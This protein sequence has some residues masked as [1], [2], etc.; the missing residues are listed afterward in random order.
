MG[1]YYKPINVDKKQ[2]V[3]SPAYG[4]GLKLM[5]HSW[6]G[7]GFVGVVEDLVAEGGAWHGDRIVWAGDYADDEK[8]R[9][10]NLWSLIGDKDKNEIQ[11][12]PTKNK[13]RYVVNLDTEEFVDTKKVPLSDVWEDPK[14][15]KEWP[16]QIHPLPI[17]TCEGNGRGG[18]DLHKE[19][20]LVGKW[21]RNRVIVS[22][23]K[24]KGYTEIE[25]NLFE[26]DKPAQFKKKATV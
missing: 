2:F 22:K 1:Q 12:E 8:N 15:G 7:N 10:S 20:P 26:G 19:D 25:F 18:G 5:E 11:P 23:R 24:P 4:N 17:L 16:Y 3:Y 9:K 14:T 21:A 6:I 13:Y